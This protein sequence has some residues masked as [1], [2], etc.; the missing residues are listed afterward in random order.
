MI[1]NKDLDMS[2]ASKTTHQW[3]FFRLGGFDQVWL[4]TEEDIRHLATLD[5]KLW[6]ALSCPVQGLEF[7]PQTL[8]MLDTDKDDRVRVPEILA[9]VA[10]VSSMLKNMDS[11]LAGQKTLP[12]SA[13][14]TSHAQGQAL[15]ASAKHIL[16]HLG[17]ENSTTISI[18]DLT[19][20]EEFFL[21]SAFNGDGVD[22]KSVV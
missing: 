22:R 2:T 10:W 16:A 15:F 20:I 5:Q 14:D 6:A 9:A 13:I 19:S 21:G 8:A 4:E 1:R 11:L 18:E 17:K 12:L 7:D 3:R